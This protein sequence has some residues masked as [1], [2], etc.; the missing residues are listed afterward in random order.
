MDIFN[1]GLT[2]EFYVLAQLNAR[3]F[4][5]SLTL[6][7]TKG[8]D[9]IVMNNINNKGYK[10][11]VKTT[12]NKPLKEKLFSKFHN[13]NPCYHWI[14]SKKNETYIA[15]NLIYCFVH[16]SDLNKM[17]KF[18]LVHSSE[19]ANYV[20]SQHKYYLS[21][22]KTTPKSDSSMRKFRIEVDDPNNYENNWSLLER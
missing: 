10:V 21:T 8:I 14:L 15:D 22:R 2:G 9:I 13:G 12:T 5:A 1:K 7:N 18:Y 20:T 4:D 17:P 3:G 6:G 16:I 19:V 11:E